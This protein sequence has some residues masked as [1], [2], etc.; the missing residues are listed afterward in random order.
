MSFKNNANKKIVEIPI[1]QI[2]PFKN[3]AR[4]NYSRE[5]LNEL[6]ESIEKNG[7]IQPLTVRKLKNSEYELITGERRLRAAA[8]CGLATVPCIII[9]CSDAEAGLFSLNENLQRSE[10][11]FFEEAEIINNIISHCHITRREL[12]NNI[13]KKISAVANKLRILDFELDERNL[14]L[15]SNLTECHAKAILKISDKTE[16]RIVLSEIIENNMNANQSE[17]YIEY[18]LHKPKPERKH[19]QYQKAIIKDIRIFEN[20]IENAVKTMRE[21]G[22]SAVEMQTENDNFIEYVIRIP[23]FPEPTDHNHGLI[24]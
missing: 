5:K 21:S 16:R 12:A 17:K 18:L 13:G 2:R 19:S 3:T 15:K 4:K 20:T 14:I 6:A 24:A 9:S 7:I 8:I 22:I 10:L 11:N 1:V 23:K